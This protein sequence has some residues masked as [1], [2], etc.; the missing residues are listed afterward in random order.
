MSLV[1]TQDGLDPLRESRL[2]KTLKLLEEGL[3]AGE[4]WRTRLL[5][6]IA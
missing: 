3:Q 1:R 6:V 5:Q 2:R 4:L